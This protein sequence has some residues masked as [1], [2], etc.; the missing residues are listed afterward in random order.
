MQLVRF[1][2]SYFSAQEYLDVKILDM[3]K[4]KNMNKSPNPDHVEGCESEKVLRYSNN[5]DEH[6]SSI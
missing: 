6:I 3:K 2:F 1:C 4:T 5:N